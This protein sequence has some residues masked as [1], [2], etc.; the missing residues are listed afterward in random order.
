M[1]TVVSA[2]FTYRV[3]LYANETAFFGYQY[4]TGSGLSK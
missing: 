4:L 2:A 3:S 1:F